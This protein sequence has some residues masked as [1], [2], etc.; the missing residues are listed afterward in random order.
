MADLSITAANVLAASGAEKNRAT[1]GAAITAGQVI[2][3]LSTDSKA[4]LADDT[5]AV[6]AAA[7]GVALNNAAIGQ[8]V[9]YISAGDFN[10]GAAV[11]VGLIYGVTDTP[12]G[13]GLV[14]E[15]ASADFVTVL[16]IATT[17]SN[18]HLSINRSGYAIA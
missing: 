7:R 16:G 3:I 1:A 13:I 2:Y 15:R 6:K 12:G 10:P 18:I 8:P 5:T 11:A 9:T 4:Y 14:S 17:T